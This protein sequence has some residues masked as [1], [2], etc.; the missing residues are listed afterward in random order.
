MASFYLAPRNAILDGCP[1]CPLIA[2]VVSRWPR[3]VKPVKLSI[4]LEVSSETEYSQMRKVLVACQRGNQG[5]REKNIGSRTVKCV[6]L[7]LP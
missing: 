7:F 5:S 6:V 2:L 1:P 4:V 3:G